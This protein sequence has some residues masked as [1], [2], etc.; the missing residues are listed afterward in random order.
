MVLWPV[1]LDAA[2]DP[3]PRQ[4]HQSRLDDV[5]PIEEIVAIHLVETDVDAPA[6]F[7]KNHEPEIFVFDVERLPRMVVPLGRNP[8][9][10]GQGIHAAAAALINALLKKHWIRIRRLRQVGE[11]VDRLLPGFY[12]TALSPWSFRQVEF[13]PFGQR[14]F[15]ILVLA[16]TAAGILRSPAMSSILDPRACLALRIGAEL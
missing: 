5:L 10:K 14:L 16:Q 15:S 9:N 11:D 6:N 2:G 3:W 8:V 4:P 13:M 12:G 7:R 1:E